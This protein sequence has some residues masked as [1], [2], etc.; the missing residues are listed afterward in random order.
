MSAEPLTLEVSHLSAP[1]VRAIGALWRGAGVRFAPRPASRQRALA[2]DRVLRIERSSLIRPVVSLLWAPRVGAGIDEDDLSLALNRAVWSEGLHD[3]TWQA[4]TAPLPERWCL[5]TP[6][7][8]RPWVLLDRP[9]ATSTQA[10]AGLTGCS[11]AQLHVLGGSV[12]R[13]GVAWLPTARVIASLLGRVHA[14]VADDGPLAWDAARAGVPWF[15]LGAAPAARD[16]A[17]RRL[18]AATVPASL[19]TDRAFWL[20]LGAQLSL[21][22]PVMGWG[23]KHW[24]RQ[25]RERQSERLR[26]A[27]PRWKRKLRKWRRDPLAFWSDSWLLRRVTGNDG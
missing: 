25:A 19:A 22:A 21:A 6:D 15:T 7:P 11:D 8:A 13:G 24:V 4:T 18:L 17:S 10:I 20:E 2:G 3:E 27:S 26:D 16:E 1:V 5:G 12:P 14:V 9:L 23:T